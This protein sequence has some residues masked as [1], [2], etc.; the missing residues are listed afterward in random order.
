MS[1]A[2][3]PPPFPLVALKTAWRGWKAGVHGIN[4][5]ISLTLMSV[6]YWGAL[7]PVALGFKLFKPDPTDRGLGDPRADSFWTPVRITPQD[8]RRC[9]RMW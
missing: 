8:L 1:V 4:G 2:A 3:Q 7:A 6:V 9:Q 5:A